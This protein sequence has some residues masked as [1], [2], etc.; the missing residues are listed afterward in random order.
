MPLLIGK[1]NA[2]EACAVVA[3]A[4]QTKQGELAGYDYIVIVRAKDDGRA[5][6]LSSLGDNETIQTTLRRLLE[7]LASGGRNT[8]RGH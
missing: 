1:L 2:E 8:L 3:N 6:V 4:L 7:H 5:S